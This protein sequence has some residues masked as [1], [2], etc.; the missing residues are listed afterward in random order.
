MNIDRSYLSNNN[1]YANNVPDYIIIHNTDNF[2][3]GADARA[4]FDFIKKVFSIKLEL[5][6]FI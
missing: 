6:R 2:K 1:T 5:L 4:F 3:K